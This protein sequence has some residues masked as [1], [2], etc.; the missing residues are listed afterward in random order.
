MLARPDASTF[1]LLPWHGHGHT[2]G[3]EPE[4]EVARVFCDIVDLDGSPFQGCPRHVLRRTLERARDRGFTF[5][6]SPEI[7][8]FYFADSDPGHPPTTLDTG[9]YF[10]LT[11]A[12]R[13]SDIR[14]RTVLTLEEMGI[15]VEHAQHE[16]APVPARDRPP[17]HRR[18]D[19]GGHGHDRAAGGQGDGPPAGRVR[20]L[21][22]EAVR[23]GA[24]LGH[25]HPPLA[26]P[27]RDQRLHRHRPARRPFGGR[28]GIH[29]RSPPPC[30]GDHRG[31]QPVGQLVQEARLG[32]RGPDPR[33][34]GA[35]QPV[36]TG[37]GARRQAREARTRP[38]SSSA[39]PTAPAT[40]T[41]PSQSSWPRVSRGSSRATSSRRRPT[42][43]SSTSRPTSSSPRG[44]SISPAPS[45]RR[46]S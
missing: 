18:P 46:S 30:R 17:L 13:A 27:R 31:H 20:Q 35:Q 40:P 22:A 4:A 36:G 5:Y 37:E 9:S 10:E 34:V 1:Q 44:S 15:P 3:D 12:D 7:E 28:R 14:Q 11:V 2:N 6:A 32:V 33:L 38:A 8:Y 24:G 26:L 23:R 29:R 42:P 41:S 21:H 39:R 25:A 43:T 45:K 19:H 16:D